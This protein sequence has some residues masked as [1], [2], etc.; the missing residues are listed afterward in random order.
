MT[1]DQFRTRVERAE[2]EVFV[3]T[4]GEDGYHVRS[5]R[6]PSNSYLVSMTEDSWLCSCPDFETHAED[7][8]WQCKHILAVKNKY[9][10]PQSYEESERAA[11]RSEGSAPEEASTADAPTQMTIKRSV[12]PDGRIDSVSIEFALPVAGIPADT[13]K[14]QALRV[15]RLQNEI[16]QQFLNLNG[17]PPATSQLRK[18]TETV[19]SS[20]PAFSTLA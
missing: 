13:I 17:K 10:E 16:A 11:I 1:Q 18:E 2:R 15:L 19:Q 7:P 14:G 4:Q 20:P 8:G 9:G 3:I 5:A 6:N 12:S